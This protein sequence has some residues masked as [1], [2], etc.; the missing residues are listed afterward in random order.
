MKT[1]ILSFLILAS[2]TTAHAAMLDMNCADSAGRYLLLQPYQGRQAISFVE[3]G[4]EIILD[5]VSAP[6]SELNDDKGYLASNKSG[7]AAHVIVNIATMLRG[8]TNNASA[9]GQILTSDGR[10][11]QLNE[12]KCTSN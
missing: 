12:F 9:W 8:V 3:N 7:D 1:S 5:N 10:L 4:K 11:I 6:L 2:S